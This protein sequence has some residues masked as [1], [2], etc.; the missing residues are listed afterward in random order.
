MNSDGGGGTCHGIHTYKQ[1]LTLCHASLL[2]IFMVNVHTSCFPTSQLA[3]TYLRNESSAFSS[4]GH[5]DLS[6]TPAMK[7]R[8]SQDDSHTNNTDGRGEAAGG[9]CTYV[10][11]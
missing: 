4:P 11:I 1:A 7:G 3:F 6:R 10:R 8:G 9:H 2:Q 5:T